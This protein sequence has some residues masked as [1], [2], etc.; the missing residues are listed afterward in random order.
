MK[1]A[2][3]EEEGAKEVD[4][5]DLGWLLGMGA[6][7]DASASEAELVRELRESSKSPSCRRSDRIRS[8]F[9]VPKSPR[10][11]KKP[12]GSSTDHTSASNASTDCGSSSPSSS[13]SSPST[14]PEAAGSEV[15][16]PRLYP[17][18]T[19]R[20]SPKPAKK[21]V[22]ELMGG[23]ASGLALSSDSVSGVVPL[24][25]IPAVN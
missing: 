24:V 8:A 19:P 2:D 3:G 11:A 10:S 17:E 13:S 15:A 7:E 21:S 22:D 5:S 4:A 23:S 1:T 6:A 12:R 20:H 9:G 14:A 16:I 25:G 18:R